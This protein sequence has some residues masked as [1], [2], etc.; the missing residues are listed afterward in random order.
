MLQ[1]DNRRLALSLEESGSGSPYQ[2]EHYERW[3]GLLQGVL[4]QIPGSTDADFTAHTLLAA[5][6]ADL[7]ERLGRAGS[8]PRDRMRTQ[9]AN[10][11]ANSSIP[12]PD[13]GRASAT[14]P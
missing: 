11:T 10:Y 2:A 8:V 6:R 7:V 4:E 1:L 3:H 13:T 12:V 14:A 5:V 9:L